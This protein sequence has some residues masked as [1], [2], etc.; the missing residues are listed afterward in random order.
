MKPLMEANAILHDD[1]Q[2]EVTVTPFVFDERQGRE[3]ANAI[4]CLLMR[5]F[6]D[7]LPADWTRLPSHFKFTTH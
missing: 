4:A 2:L 7:N 6:G 1:G 5:T 3:L